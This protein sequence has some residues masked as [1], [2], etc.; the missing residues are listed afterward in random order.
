MEDSQRKSRTR[1]LGDVPKPVA[2]RWVSFKT[3]KWAQVVARA[4]MRWKL[5]WAERKQRKALEE[6]FQTARYWAARGEH[7]KLRASAMLQN[8]G[9]YLL[10]ADKDIQALKVDALTHPDEWTRKLS[11]RVIL[12][13]IYEWD[14]DEVT[15]KTL[16]EA[17]DLM[18]IPEELQREAF[19]ALR[20]LR[21]VQ[22][23]AK[24]NFHFIRN[25]AIAH[26]DPNALVQYRAIRDLN[27]KH[28]WDVGAEFFVAIE[29]LINVLTKLMAAGN[30][31][32]SFLRQWAAASKTEGTQ[33]T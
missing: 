12:L 2:K 33:K 29:G 21:K 13:T 18:L 10:L 32:E 7:S 22:E 16:K 20:K 6:A 23:K 31:P 15:G 26:R 17:L 11:A 19:T 1:G 4:Y 14:A 30:T 27:V 3:R 25:A 24:K 28:V 8:I 5:P 9:L